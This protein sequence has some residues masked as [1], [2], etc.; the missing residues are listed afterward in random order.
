MTKDIQGKVSLKSLKENNFQTKSIL[1]YQQGM[2]GEF[3]PLRTH[4]LRSGL[5]F[6]VLFDI[7]SLIFL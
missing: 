3:F 7:L 6:I 2:Q 5:I 1:F 4:K